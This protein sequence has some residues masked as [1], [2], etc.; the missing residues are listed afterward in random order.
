MAKGKTAV[1]SPRVNVADRKAAISGVIDYIGGELKILSEG[2]RT[3]DDSA[4]SNEELTRLFGHL[5]WGFNDSLRHATDRIGLDAQEVSAYAEEEGAS[6]SG[7]MEGSEGMP[8]DL[9]AV[10]ASLMAEESKEEEK[11]P[12]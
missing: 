1:P 6:A 9:R 11:E 4:F 10:L 12:A 2:V 7:P 5:V 8:E 3:L